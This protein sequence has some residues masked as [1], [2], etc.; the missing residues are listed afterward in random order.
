MVIIT[1]Q[2]S[3]VWILYIMNPLRRAGPYSYSILILCMPVLYDRQAHNY[4]M[5]LYRAMEHVDRGKTRK[6]NG[7]YHDAMMM[8]TQLPY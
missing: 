2:A 8:D 6:D 5:Y 4:C 7:L 3:I 1:V